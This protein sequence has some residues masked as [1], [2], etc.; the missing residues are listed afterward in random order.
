MK[1]YLFTFGLLF[2]LIL[3]LISCRDHLLE[4]AI[5][6]HSGGNLDRALELALEATKKAPNNSEAWYWLGEIHYA[7]NQIQ[8][9]LNAFNKSLSI[10]NK[11][12]SKINNTKNICF[13]DLYNKGVSSYNDYVNIQD[14]TT[15][16]AKKK[17]MS[18]I[19]N[20][21]NTILVKNNYNANRLIANAYQ[22]LGDSENNL[23][24]LLAASE[25]QPDTV[26][27]WLD[28]GYHYYNLENYDKASE[29]FKKGLESNP[30]NTECLTMYAQSLNFSGRGE[31]AEKAFIDAIKQNPDEKA[32]PFNL[33]LIYYKQAFKLK[34]EDPKR[35]DLF[36][37]AAELF[38]KAYE[39]DTEIKDIY[40]LLSF[41][42][43]ELQRYEE[44]I[45][46]LKQGIEIYP[47]NY[48]IWY[49]LGVAY[50]RMGNE[51]KAKEA[52]TKSDQLK[53]E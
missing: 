15:D 1:N 23:K 2:L 18:A 44:A 37:K 20:F 33:G 14:K 16:T 24:Y 30:A 36:K 27:A 7:K 12:E 52:F 35:V 21:N 41:T 17:L 25:I 40:V 22:F 31:D 53:T 34:T 51:E 45:E 28:L 5:L 39:I 6:E 29:Y 46:L 48:G 50:A 13:K 9:M 10:N 47:D 4:G 11:F 26:Q 49:N 38:Y 8:D 43:I 3:I 42:L 32:L 19:E